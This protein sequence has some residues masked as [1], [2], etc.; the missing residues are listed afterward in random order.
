MSRWLTDATMKLL[1]AEEMAIKKASMKNMGMV[2][3]G[4]TEDGGAM[5]LMKW[6]LGGGG[7]KK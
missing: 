3:S 6:T 5:T 1:K 2:E 7:D 4:N